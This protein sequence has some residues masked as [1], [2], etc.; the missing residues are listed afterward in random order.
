LQRAQVL[1]SNNLE[2]NPSLMRLTKIPQPSG[3]SDAYADFE[4]LAQ[5]GQR[6]GSSPNNGGA[7]FPTSSTTGSFPNG[8]TM[9]PP[10]NGTGLR[11]R[12]HPPR[13]RST[14]FVPP[15]WQTPPRILLVED[16]ATCARIGSKFLQTAE[17]NVDLAVRFPLSF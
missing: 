14:P 16:D 17:C 11:G 10:H 15:N 8:Y 5:N 3:Q 4:R 9:H 1:L 13:K 7:G 12:S 6:S 2:A